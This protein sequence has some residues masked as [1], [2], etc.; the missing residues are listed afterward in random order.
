MKNKRLHAS[1]SPIR[2]SFSY[3]TAP[4]WHFPEQA[5]LLPSLAGWEDWYRV[6]FYNR[7]WGWPGRHE[8]HNFL[9]QE[10]EIP[11]K[12]FGTSFSSLLLQFNLK[13]GSKSVWTSQAVIWCR[14]TRC[15][16]FKPNK[17][18]ICVLQPSERKDSAWSAGHRSTFHIS[19]R[20]LI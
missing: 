14:Q 13:R 3:V 7:K 15:E 12:A 9:D 1:L 8:L 6:C 11:P 16:S 2:N 18:K 4:G 19:S 5:V 20:S 17:I 10:Q